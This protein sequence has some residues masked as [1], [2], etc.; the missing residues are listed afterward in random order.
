MSDH[1]YYEKSPRKTAVKLWVN[2]LLVSVLFLYLYSNAFLNALDTRVFFIILFVTAL[3][4]VTLFGLGV[5]FWVK[6]DIFYI[7]VNDTIFESHH[8]LF[9]GFSFKILLADIK[10]IKHFYS[11]ES[12]QWSFHVYKKDETYHQ[13]CQH[14]AYKREE[15]YQAIET[16]APHVQ[17]HDTAAN[18]KRPQV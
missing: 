14:A 9:K 18:S 13:I 1:F 3:V 8:P 15:L 5:Y 6:N 11:A 12:R 7:R 16:V 4:A 10:E 17:I 2:S